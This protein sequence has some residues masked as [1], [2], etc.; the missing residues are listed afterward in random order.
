MS[1]LGE[2]SLTFGCQYGPGRPQS[3]V[4]HPLWPPADADGYVTILA[5]DGPA[6]RACAFRL[7]G[8]KWSNIYGPDDVLLDDVWFPLGELARI[9]HDDVALPDVTA[10]ELP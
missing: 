7:F 9:R 10:V 4:E 5:P 3:R 1:E 8:Q 2:Y 6:A